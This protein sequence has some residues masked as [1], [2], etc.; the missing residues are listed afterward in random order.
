MLEKV[1]DIFSDYLNKQENQ[2]KEQ[3]DGRAG[4]G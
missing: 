2:E 3:G 1:K 4:V